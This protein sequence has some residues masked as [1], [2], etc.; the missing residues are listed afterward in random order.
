M[1]RGFRPTHSTIVSYLA[2][3]VAL[4]TGGAYAANE[5]T[6]ENI[7]DGSITSAD[8]R[9]ASV[10]GGDLAPNAVNTTRIAQD[11][12]TTS[13]IAQGTVDNADLAPNSIT[14]TRIA[15]NSIETL[16]ISDRNI[17]TAD[18]AL[19]AVTTSRVADGSIGEVDLAG[20][21]VT[22]DKIVDQGVTS[23]DVSDDDLS[24][25]DINENTLAEVPQATNT[26]FLDGHAA[27]AFTQE[28][29]IVGARVYFGSV[30]GGHAERAVGDI[31]ALQG[32]NDGYPVRLTFTRDLTDCA[33]VAAGD[34]G[35][36][37]AVSLSTVD[38]Y[39]TSDFSVVG[40]CP[41]APNRVV[42][43]PTE[44]P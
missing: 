3:F 12:V 20:N 36:R 10:T 37:T 9:D 27:S 2:L 25:A 26:R 29:D 19:D 1:R 7:V 41:P 35:A 31:T 17:F 40:Y 21:A 33:V 39:A 32:G 15:S 13:D 11:A 22:T 18:L 23:A 28:A 30:A 34:P 6:G 14:S 16:D 24:G 4:G 44:T 43:A 38:V 8:I 5:W 42:G